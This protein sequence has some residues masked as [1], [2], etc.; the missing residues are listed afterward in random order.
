MSRRHVR[1]LYRAA[2]ICMLGLAC[3]SPASAEP[4]EPGQAEELY[5]RSGLERYFAGL[6][7]Q[8]T[9]QL[10]QA[11]HRGP[12][13]GPFEDVVL[14]ASRSSFAAAEIEQGILQSMSRHMDVSEAR[15]ALR[16]LRSEI[17]EKITGAELATLAPDAQDGIEQYARSVG[18]RLPEQRMA[19][20]QRLQTALGSVDLGL[21]VA[22][23]MGVA[24]GKALAR[25]Q[26]TAHRP[27]EFLE[28]FEA[29][30]AHLRTE[31]ERSFLISFLYTY[32]EVT[33]R[34]LL[35]YLEYLETE[36]GRAYARALNRAMLEA[37]ASATEHFDTRIASELPSTDAPN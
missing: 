29:Q 15:A 9:G 21:A 32:R 6:D 30:S 5:R 31:L 2:W 35:A 25:A 16:W 26:G 23:T 20:L 3:C 1:S 24:T 7:D 17:G 14:D 36:P 33:D 28:R 4:I 13:H 27:D 10:E 12:R 11:L 18:A 34:D 19:L 8:V 22:R 37:L